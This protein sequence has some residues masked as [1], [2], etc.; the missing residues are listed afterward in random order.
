MEQTYQII[1]QIANT[2]SIKKKKEILADNADNILLK[3]I[4]RFCFSPLIVTGISEAKLNKPV[5][6]TNQFVYNAK[7]AC[8]AL[9]D[10]LTAHNTGS[11]D[12][13]SVCQ[14]VLNCY[15]E[16]N[17]LFTAI[18]TKT[19]KIGCDSKTLNAVYGKDFI[20]TWEVQRAISIEHTKLK[21]NEWIAISEKL[22]G[23]RGTY[24]QGK[25]ISR[26]GKEITGLQHIIDDIV[27]AGLEH[28]VLDGE[29]RRKN[30]DH[31]PDNE[32]FRIG[33]GIINSDADTKSEINFTIYD[34]LNVTDWQ[35][36][37]SAITYRQRLNVLNQWDKR[38]KDQN[39]QNISIVDRLYSGTDHSQ[40]EICL[41]K[42]VDEDK[43]GCMV[44]RDVPYKCKRHNGILKVK[45]FYTCDLPIIRLE[46]G[47]GR[48]SGTLGNFVVDYKGNEV[49]V[50]SGMTDEQREVFWEAGDSL[51]GRVIEVKYKEVSQDK[52]TKKESLQFPI[53][54]CLREDGKEVSYE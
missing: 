26:Q 37:E 15:P 6:P 43:E 42:M 22:N 33:T 48:L 10:H 13:I 40:I 35:M 46:E 41:Q 50:G 51:I 53:F 2:S 39:L 11:D 27:S 23:V 36:G 16:Y 21:K 24:Y 14:Y 5:K 12:D 30:I 8:C 34:C 25:I 29:L 17:D 52:T 9:M 19:L 38:I 4:L 18:I 28:Y 32:N 45:R 54:V 44:N 31:I 49:S 20:P 47:S 7:L 1:K 3:D